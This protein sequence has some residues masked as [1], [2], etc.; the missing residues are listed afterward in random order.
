MTINIKELTNLHYDYLI[1]RIKKLAMAPYSTKEYGDLN[2]MVDEFRCFV[3]WIKDNKK[4]QGE[5]KVDWPSGSEIEARV[6]ECEDVVKKK[7]RKVEKIGSG[8]QVEGKRM[9]KG[10][11]IGRLAVNMVEP[12]LVRLGFERIGVTGVFKQDGNPSATFSFSSLANH[13]ALERNKAY[14]NGCRD[15]RLELRSEKDKETDFK[16]IC[17]LV[18]S[19]AETAQKDFEPPNLKDFARECFAQLLTEYHL[20]KT[21]HLRILRK[22]GVLGK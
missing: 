14:L 4:S 21:G 17:D 2:E 15:G 1:S 11:G 18:A 12:F 8:W 13:M 20:Y 22:K 9:N 7:T 6:K 5:S 19:L 10:I 3:K 16:H